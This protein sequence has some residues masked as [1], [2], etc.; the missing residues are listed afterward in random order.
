MKQLFGRPGRSIIAITALLSVAAPMVATPAPAQLP[1]PPLEAP[2][3]GMPISQGLGPTYGDEWCAPPAPGTSIASQQTAPLALIPQEAV[4][5]TLEKIEAEGAAAGIPDR[6]DY[7]VIGKSAGGLDVHGVIVNALETAEQQRDYERWQQIREIELT[8]PARA[9]ALL[10]SFGDDVKMPIFIQ[11]N[12]HGNEEEG[13]DAILQVIRDLVTLPRGT[14]D[15]VDLILDNAILIVV[16]MENPD[17]RLAGTR[18]NG[19]AFDMNRDW[20]VQSQS[21][22]R[23]SARF[24]LEWL[25]TA[26]LDMHGYVEPTLVDGTTK[27]HNPGLE[28]DTFLY[29]NQRRLDANEQAYLDIGMGI[30]RPVNQWGQ[31]GTPPGDPS[32]A[33]GW[34]DWGPF[35]TQTYMAF[36]GVDS[37]TLEMCMVPA[38]NCPTRLGSKTAQYVG[39]YSS[40]NFWLQN[41]AD[42][43][44]AQ[45]EIFRR[46]V[47]DQGRPACCADAEIASR[48]FTEDQHNWMIEYPTAYVIPQGGGQR[49]DA[50]ANRMVQWLL[51]NGVEV[52]RMTKKFTWQG[53][54]FRKYSYVVWMDQAFRGLALTALSAGQDISNRITQLYSPPAAWSHGFLWGADVLEIPRA[55]PSFN[56][57]T[58]SVQATNPLKG[59]KVRRR[60]P[61]GRRVWFAVTL[62]GMPEFR[63]ILDVLRKGVKAR[64]AEESFRKK[65]RTMPAGTLIFR[66]NRKAVKALKGA[67]A[68]AGLRISRHSRKKP[69]STAL[70]EAPKVAILVNSAAPG[71]TDTSESLRAIFGPDVGFVSVSTGD[72]SLQNAPEDP[73]LN[74]DVIYNTGQAWPTD[75]TA[76]DRLRAF[77]ERGGGYIATSQSANNFAFLTGGG[78]VSG[79]FTQG[80]QTADG[81]IA[82]WNNVGGAASPVTGGYPTS[83]FLF[84][85]QGVTYFTATPEGSVIDGRYH[86]DMVGTAPHGPSPGFVA[87]LWRDRTAAPNG[88]PVIVHGTTTADSRYLGFATNPFSRQD[89]E[90]EWVLIA[91]SVLW[92]NLTDDARPAAA[93]RKRAA[94]ADPDFVPVYPGVEDTQDIPRPPGERP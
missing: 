3:N 71:R 57:Q 59:S 55:D 27:P 2:W 20:L 37:S 84:L 82:V 74:Y 51:D 24:Q 41:K 21:E 5:C 73:L 87:G 8:D 35:Y 86:D 28:Y 77:F 58:E 44:D 12:I 76:Q 46:G 83:D 15:I 93:R 36:Y 32:T 14:N 52:T 31:T 7:F 48:G 62:R 54:T 10:A 22:V 65:K 4:G 19:N 79:S 85:P 49:S 69:P 66:G 80:S 45:L 17:G 89:A 43:M 29:W 94:G 68:Q 60:Q 53:R 34:D 42:M 11:A 40:A 92:S 50:E 18:A 1:L 72:Q 75:T 56:P 9:Q 16:P 91:Q 78:L 30:T 26:G 6:M 67:S 13:T 64:I 81:G 25:G 61:G 90:R 88:A 63:A 70:G 23:A 47:A 33:E 39:F 38:G